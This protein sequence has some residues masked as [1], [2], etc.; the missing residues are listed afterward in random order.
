MRLGR[1]ASMKRADGRTRDAVA[2]FGWLAALVVTG[3]G[4]SI[5]WLGA[6][7][8]ALGVIA[9]LVGD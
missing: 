3:G 4:A 2:D 1:V 7:A 5:A 8:Y 6:I 9:E